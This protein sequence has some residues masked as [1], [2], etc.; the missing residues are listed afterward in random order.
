MYGIPLRSSHFL[1]RIRGYIQ[2]D[3]DAS[4]LLRYGWIPSQHCWI[5]PGHNMLRGVSV[6]VHFVETFKIAGDVGQHGIGEPQPTI[7]VKVHRVRGENDRTASR[8]GD[9]K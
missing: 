3:R 4:E 1:R 6:A 7:V 2:P 5:V 8:R 9:N